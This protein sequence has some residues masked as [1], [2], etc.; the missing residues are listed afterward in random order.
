MGLGD[1]TPDHLF[2]LALDLVRVLEADV[3]GGLGDDMGVDAPVPVAELDVQAPLDLGVRLHDPAHPRRELGVASR[4]VFAGDDVGIHRLEVDVDA[5]D[6]GQLGA[7]RLLQRAT[8]LRRP[9]ERLVAGHL[10]VHRQ[11]QRSVRLA[12][13]G[14]VVQ[15]AHPAVAC[16]GGVDA[17][18]QVALLLLAFDR[19]GEVEA[20]KHLQRL[21][22]DVFDER[23]GGLDREHAAGGDARVTDQVGAGPA[24]ADRPHLADAVDVL[25]GLPEVALRPGGRAV[26]QDVPRTPGQQ[27]GGAEDDQRDHQRR[28]RVG[29]E[30]AHA[31]AGQTDK[32]SGV[33]EHVG[34]AVGRVGEHRF[35]CDRAADAPHDDG[36]D[37]LDQDR[38]DEEGEGVAGGIDGGAARVQAPDRLE[39]DQGGDHEQE[40][41]LGERGQVL[42]TAMAVGMLLVRGFA[43]GAD[44]EQRE[45]ACG[46]VE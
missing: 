9:G 1:L 4:D 10:G 15:V 24:D 42:R 40:E 8:G 31:H 33:G 37:R 20:R 35:A 28:R 39:R 34:Q 25:D 36:S 26:D 6:L 46:E 44:G 22:L 29:P 17:L 32:D 38:G 2:E 41:P 14:D 16:R 18:D 11:V 43:G 19:D 5:R 3:P 27:S 45:D 30:H 13:D 21:L 23:A 7:D 12:F